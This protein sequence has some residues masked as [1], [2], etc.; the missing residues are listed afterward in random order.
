MSWGHLY[1]RQARVVAKHVRG[2]VV[3]DL[4]CGDLTLTKKL[5][6]LGA[7]RV[8]GVDH[9]VEGRPSDPRMH[10]VE[11]RFENYMGD[12]DVAFLSWPINWT[13]GVSLLAARAKTVIYLG[14][15]TGGFQCGTQDLFEG[16]LC[17]DLAAYVPHRKNT[18][19]VCGGLRDT[20]RA[21]Q[22]E[23]WAAL[24]YEIVGYAEAEA[25]TTVV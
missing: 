8:I 5:L 15:N 14:C 3:H 18:L 17:R 11:T 13:S 7:A 25:V 23:E 2:R 24:S 6:A 20:R 4:G 22:G 9:R 1:Y 19:I 21:P 10:L 16:F 12:I